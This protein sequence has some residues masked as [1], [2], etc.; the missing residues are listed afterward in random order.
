MLDTEFKIKVDS[1]DSV[2]FIQNINKITERFVEKCEIEELFFI[3]V[4]NWFDHKWLNYSGKSVIQFHGGPFLESALQ[5]EWR[6][7]I[8]VP[9]FNPSRIISEIFIKIGFSQPKSF[10]KKLH[11]LKGSNDNIHNRIVNFTKNGLFAWYSSNTEI[12]QIGSLMIY[13]VKDNS[14]ETFY[15]S[16]ANKN[17]W[18]INLAKNINKRE[19][20]GLMT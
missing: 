2:I 17:G 6:D 7:K 15:V 18:N 11:S 20:T 8:T 13:I 4:E 3:K 1:G 14:V 9:P 16:F 12:N 5:N 19:L 10:H